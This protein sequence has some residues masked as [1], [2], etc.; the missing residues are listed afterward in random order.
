MIFL[1]SNADSQV[2]KEHKQ[3]VNISGF[4]QICRIYCTSS[5]FNIS[6]FKRLT[7]AVLLHA[8]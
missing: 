7:R 2:L 8:I 4:R 3:F 5:A 6:H 1:R